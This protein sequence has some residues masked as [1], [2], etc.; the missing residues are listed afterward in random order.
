MGVREQ[1]NDDLKAAMRAKETHRLTLIR[2]IM[3]AFKEAEQKK[4]EDLVKAALKKHAVMRPA[5]Q[6]DPAAMAQYNK[7]VTAA[8][9]TEKV[10]DNAAVHEGEL[11]AIV[12]K[13]IKMRQ[14]S[15]ADADKASR[16]DIAELEKQEMMWLQVYLPPQLSREDVEAEARTAIAEIGASGPKD[17]GK[18]MG[19]LSAKLRGQADGKLISEIVKALLGG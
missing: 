16:Q 17:M 19:T 3:A 2:G 13:L 12:Q 6:D 7:A 11:L 18:V 8:L 1:L 15:I 10:E 4:R 9:S 5:S 14:D